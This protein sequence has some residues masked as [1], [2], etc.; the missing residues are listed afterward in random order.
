MPDRHQTKSKY[1]LDRQIPGA[2]E[3]ETVTRRRFMTGTTHAAGAIAASAF[4]LPAVGFALGPIFEKHEEPWQ[5]VG[6]VDEF[7]DDTYVPRT[8]SIA[9]GIGETGKSTVYIRKHNEAIDG[10]MR[11]SY[12]QWIAISTRCMHLGCPVR[13]VGAA[14]R[15][16]CPCHGGVY[17]FL[18]KVSGGPPVR[19]LDRFYSRQRNG[20]VQLGP[21]YSVNSQLRRFSPRDPGEPLDGIGQYLYPSRPTMRKLPNT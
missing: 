4:L 19:P 5:D 8:I 20:R 7:P 18:G 10:P 12:D 21:R 13:F 14:Q 17:D 1:T 3:G 6:A 11:D 2:F 9:S 15:F 16:I